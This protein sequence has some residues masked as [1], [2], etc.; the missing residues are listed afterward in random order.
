MSKFLKGLKGLFIEEV[1]AEKGKTSAPKAKKESPTPRAKTT[2]KTTT[3]TSAPSSPSA[4]SAGQVEEKFINILLGAME[5][6]NIEGFDYLEFKQSL[7]ALEDMPMDEA[8]RYKSA[9]AMAKSMGVSSDYLVKTADHYLKVLLQEEQKFEKALAGQNQSKIG[10]QQQEIKQ[11]ENAVKEKEA[12]M[13]KLT[14]EVA[15]MKKSI[16][17][18]QGQIQKSAGKIEQTKRNFIATYEV[19]RGQIVQDVERMKQ[20]LD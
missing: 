5:K 19:L 7:Q 10:A 9:F 20:Y 3:S 6:N 8:T 12:Q 2:Q 15:K 18:K 13:K 11:L 4:P 16:T 17:T 14:Q 1:P